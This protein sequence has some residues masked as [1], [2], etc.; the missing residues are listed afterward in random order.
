[1]ITRILYYTM[2]KNTWRHKKITIL[3]AFLCWLSLWLIILQHKTNLIRNSLC[4]I[5]MIMLAN[6]HRRGRMQDFWEWF[7]KWPLYDFLG[8]K[9]WFFDNSKTWIDDYH[10]LSA[11]IFWHFFLHT[12]CEIFEWQVY[13]ILKH[14]VASC[15]EAWSLISSLCSSFRILKLKIK[16]R[17]AKYSF[18]LD[19]IIKTKY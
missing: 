13:V 14:T 9:I 1:M 4:W 5:N 8:T 17:H 2:Q 10:V 7:W 12:R 16:I 18:I 19:Y 3:G 6:I 11:H 15:I